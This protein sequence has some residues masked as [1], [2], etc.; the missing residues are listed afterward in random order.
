MADIAGVEPTLAEWLSAQLDEDGQ[1]ALVATSCS[2][3]GLYDAREWRVA[4]R[5]IVG[6]DGSDDP[7]DIAR[8]RNEDPGLLDHIAR[9]DPARVLAEVEAKRFLVEQLEIELDDSE[10]AASAVRT[11]RL[12][13]LPYADRAGYREEWKP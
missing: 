10:L 1:V 11:L 2:E 13:A 5:E 6:D 7:L 12:L 3:D 4:D 9:W 8:A